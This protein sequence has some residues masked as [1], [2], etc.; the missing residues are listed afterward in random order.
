[1]WD[2]DLAHIKATGL[3]IVRSFNYWNWMEPRLDAYEL[4][5]IDRLFDLTEKHDLCVWLDITLATH[6]PCPEWLMRE[7][8][9]IRAVDRQGRPVMVWCNRLRPMVDIRLSASPGGRV[10]AVL[11]SQPFVPSHLQRPLWSSAL[12]LPAVS[13]PAPL[14]GRRPRRSSSQYQ[15]ACLCR[16]IRMDRL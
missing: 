4:N 11:R 6:S 10:A 1:V 15:C 5:D 13:R 12:Q 16:R 14:E 3:R 8:P 2:E 9:D 7:H